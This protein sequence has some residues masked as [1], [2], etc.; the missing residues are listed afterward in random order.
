MKQ[1]WR[2]FVDACSRSLVGSTEGSRAASW[3]TSVVG[4]MKTAVHER[5]FLLLVL[6]FIKMYCYCVDAEEGETLVGIGI[7]LRRGARDVPQHVQRDRV[8]GCGRLR[9]G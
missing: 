5:L 9:A 2:R 3:G 1:K 6:S 4:R 8:G 7:A